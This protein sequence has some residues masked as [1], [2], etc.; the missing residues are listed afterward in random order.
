MPKR[1][2]KMNP[3]APPKN[4]I[5][6]VGPG[7][8]TSQWWSH[9]WTLHDQP[10]MVLHREPFRL[11]WFATQVV[12]F[13]FV[14]DR[15]PGDI[16]SVDADYVALR[17]FASHNKRTWLPFA[18]QCCYA[19]LPIYTGDLFSDSLVTEIRTR[20]KKRWCVFH[21]PSLMDSNTGTVYTLQHKSIW[22]GMYRSY[23]HTTIGQVSHAVRTGMLPA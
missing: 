12:T 4:S 19:L 3:Y 5:P 13:V 11:K 6:E 17:K 21:V 8:H 14:I 23:I 20:N 1:I 22:G 7:L 10:V 2:C 15:N 18:F 9:S 16:E